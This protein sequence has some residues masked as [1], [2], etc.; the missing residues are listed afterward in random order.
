MGPAWVDAAS[1]PLAK[2]HANCLLVLYYA[3][4]MQPITATFGVL[5]PK[6]RAW[7]SSAAR[8]PKP[9]TRMVTC[10]QRGAGKLGVRHTA[11]HMIDHAMCLSA[12]CSL[13]L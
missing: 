8:L 5:E 7:K 13:G 10:K 1:A 3:P 11:N 6:T 2:P 12:M 4:R 9:S